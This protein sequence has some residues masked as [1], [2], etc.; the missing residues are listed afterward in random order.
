MAEYRLMGT[1]CPRTGE[2]HNWIQ[3]DG[4]NVTLEDVVYDLLWLQAKADRACEW[5]DDE[6]CVYQTECGRAWQFVDGSVAENG[7]K[8]CPFCGGRVVEAEAAGG[9]DE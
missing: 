4:T 7:V 6:D 1:E 8:F 3:R 9:G 5:L 2:V